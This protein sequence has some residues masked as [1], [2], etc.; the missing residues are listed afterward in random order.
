MFRSRHIKTCRI[1]FRNAEILV[2]I[3]SF[4][5]RISG[6]GG[7]CGGGGGGDDDDNWCVFFSGSKD[8]RDS[9]YIFMYR[10]EK[11]QR[12]VG[13]KT[14]FVYVLKFQFHDHNALYVF[15]TIKFRLV[16]TPGD[17]LPRQ[18]KWFKFASDIWSLFVKH[19]GIQFRKRLES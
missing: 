16:P 13:I 15:V 14:F 8:T 3:F 2:Y 6:G 10:N 11:T 19:W 4:T 12:F 18:N 1:R 7:G 5:E 9:D 17:S